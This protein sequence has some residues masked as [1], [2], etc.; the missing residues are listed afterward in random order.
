VNGEAAADASRSLPRKSEL[1]DEDR[2]R[3]GEAVIRRLKS[4]INGRSHAVARTS[5]GDDFAWGYNGFGQL[6][7]NTTAD[8]NTPVA[9]STY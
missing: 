3:V 6:G 1:D 7:D 5:A 2:R 4:E 8:K 9:V